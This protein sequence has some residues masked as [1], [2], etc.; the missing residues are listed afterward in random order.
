MA[1]SQ[2]L[3]SLLG[4]AEIFGAPIRFARKPLNYPGGFQLVGDLS[5][6]ADRYPKFSRQP[7]SGAGAFMENIAGPQLPR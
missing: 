6:G 7:G 1:R 2:E 4:Q 3:C 5:D